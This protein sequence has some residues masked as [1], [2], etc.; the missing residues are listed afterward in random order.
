MRIN[1]YLASCGLGSRRAVEALIGAGKVTL[2]GTI[3]RDLSTQ[4]KPTGDEVTVEGRPARPAPLFTYLALNKPLGYDVTRGGEQHHRRAWDLLPKGTHPSV[5]SVGRLDRDS[6]GLL[7]FTNDGEFAFRLAHP[8]HGCT[9]TYDVEIAGGRPTPETLERLRDGVTLED[10]PARALAVEPLPGGSGPERS[11]LRLVIGEGRNRIVRRM[12]EAVGHPVVEL[13]RV[14]IGRLELG[15]LKRGKCR[16]LTAREVVMLR[17]DAGL[18]PP[19]AEASP[20]KKGP[21]PSPRAGGGQNP[22]TKKPAGRDRR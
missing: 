21:R 12:C 17:R 20:P 8:R 5:Q 2:N 3:V 7:L 18:A 22:R 9:K 6:T 11:R 1:R 14:A 4:V 10:G 15:V 16:P 19:E 13:E